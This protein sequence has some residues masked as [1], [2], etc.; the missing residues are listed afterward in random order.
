MAFLTLRVRTFLV[1]LLII[2]IAFVL[3]GAFSLFH[4]REEYTNYHYERLERKEQAI[5]SHLDYV[6]KEFQ[7]KHLSA[8]QWR[9]EIAGLI[10]EINNIHHLD[11]AVYH[12]SG[13]MIGGS[14]LF[15]KDLE[16]LPARVEPR[17]RDGVAVAM[18]HKLRELTDK[19]YII[20]TSELLGPDN[21]VELV[22]V[23]PYFLEGNTIPEDDY[24]FLRELAGLYAILFVLGVV[25]AFI[26]SNYI[27]KTFKTISTKL[28]SVRLNKSNEK[29][30][31]KYND[32][33]GQ[34]INEYNHMVA[35]LEQTAVELAKSERES[36]WK[37]MA[38]QV[39]HEIKNPLTPMRLTLQMMERSN[40]P[41]DVREMTRS[42]L[43]EVESLTHIAEAFSR[44]AQ[45]P[46]LNISKVDIAELTQ[47]AGGLYADRGVHIVAGEPAYAEVDKEQWSRI[48]HNLIK[49][50]LQSVAEGVEPDVRVDVVVEKPWI[51]IS[52]K[53]NGT[54]IAEEMKS[55][56][57]EPNF[58]TKSSG[59]GLG[60]AMVQNLVQSFN[61]SIGFETSERGTT[62]TIK[63]PLKEPNSQ[64]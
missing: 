58:S 17:F 22:V 7:G 28:R 64:A 29:I 38:Q 26:L 32:E 47:R 20:S 44:F 62:F 30:E 45:M 39:A 2:V 1:M 48:I 3:T 56:V 50:A 46:A 15:T 36:A 43:E 27:N 24:E 34:L 37:E 9:K 6:S 55:R 14:V 54:G 49:N 21:E 61:G 60:L 41:E 33:I 31:W 23:I 52:V 42:L 25:L 53:D 4:F 35:K 11:L 18:G 59:M 19:N 16:V 10:D 13:E 63:L 12:P 40:D 8:V 5:M 57:F 51:E